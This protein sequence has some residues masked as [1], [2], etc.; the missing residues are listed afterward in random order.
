MRGKPL[1]QVYKLYVL[2]TWQANTVQILIMLTYAK[3]T[4]EAGSPVVD[5][6]MSEKA[7]ILADIITDWSN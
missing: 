3:G 1:Q 5:L 6:P 4:M 7:G 2:C